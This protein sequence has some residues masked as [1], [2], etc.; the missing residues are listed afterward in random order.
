MLS[1][2]TVVAEGIRTTVGATGL[3]TAIAAGAALP[4]AQAQG[5]PM[6]L[7][8]PPTATIT[9]RLSPDRLGA[10]G[11]FTVAIHYAGGEFGVPS[12]VR[13]ATLK[14]P[15]GL[16]LE[17]P[18]LYSCGARRLLTHGP[19]A[20]PPRSKLGGG[21]ALAAVHLGTET[22]SENAELWAFLGPLTNNLEPTFEILA[23]G[24][25]PVDERMVLS[26]TVQVTNAPYGEELELTIPP[27]PTLMFEPDA[28][29]VSF[30]LTIGKTGQHASATAGA[31]VVPPRCPAGGFPF[32]AE[33]S[34]AEGSTGTALATVPCP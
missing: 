33:F 29:I 26:G 28:S 19:N 1:I 16:S 27:I 18:R 34:Y 9:P 30:S 5:T 22:I 31:I 8:G 4:S 15:A 2:R 11:S 7:S 12:P 17:I 3:R 14:L 13:K 6:V 25:T 32:A 10:K 20:C 23:Q 24:Y 21:R